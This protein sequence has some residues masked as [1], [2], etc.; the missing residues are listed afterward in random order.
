[1]KISSVRF[2]NIN[3]LRGE[4]FLAFDAAPLAESGLF[5]ITG[6]T[7]AGKT[8]ILDAITVALY[9]RAARY[10]DKS[11]SKPEN[12]M[13]RGTGE[14]YAEVEFESDGKRYRAKWSLTRAR[15]KADGAL[16]S[17]KMELSELQTELSK[18]STHPEHSVT[19]AV[20]GTLLTQKKS[21]VPAKVEEISGLSYEQFLRSVMLAQGKFAEFLKA[22]ES[23]RA[24]LLEH[25]TGTS[26]YTRIS[27]AAF[28]KAKLANEALQRLT[29]KLGDLR[30]LT[31][32]ERKAHEMCIA[33]KNNASA[34]LN[35]IIKT[36]RAALQWANDLATL[37]REHSVRQRNAEAAQR[38]FDNA[39][40]ERRTLERH[41]QS[42]Q[43]QARL[44]LLDK[45]TDEANKLRAALAE[46]ERTTIPTAS[47]ALQAAQNLAMQHEQTH[48]AAQKE[49][50]EAQA[51]FDDV[52]R[53]DSALAAEAE[54]LAKD[55]EKSS[56]VGTEAKALRS[57]VLTRTNARNEARASADKALLWLQQHHADKALEAALPMLRSDIENITT[58][59]QEHHTASKALAQHQAQQREA[60]ERVTTCTEDA[61]TSEK[62]LL[63]ATA[64]LQALH[65]H[66]EK[67][68]GGRT[69][70]ELE[71]RI[72]TCKDDGVALAQMIE[73]LETIIQRSKEYQGAEGT[74]RETLVRIG[75]LHKQQ[76]ELAALLAEQE[77]KRDLARRVLDQS[78]LIAKYEDDR[79]RLQ[80][81]APC[82]L[83]GAV[84]HP[85]AESDD[86]NDK[87]DE[88][89]HS[90]DEAA[91]KK[92]EKDVKSTSQQISRVQADVSSART[93]Q[94]N[95]EATIARLQTEMEKAQQQ[96]NDIVTA[97]SASLGSPLKA[98][99]SA[100]AREHLREAQEA[101]QAKR[102]EYAELSETKKTLDALHATIA[103][104]RTNTDSAKE[105]SGKSKTALELAAQT[106][107]QL[108]GNTDMLQDRV[109]T[110]L[111]ALERSK[112]TLA[113][114]CAAFDE[115]LPT[116][117][118][119]AQTL[120][121]QLEKR[122]ADFAEQLSTEQRLRGEAERLGAGLIELEKNCAA[123]EQETKRL[124]EDLAAKET[125]HQRLRAQRFAIFGDK[126]PSAERQRL[127]ASVDAAQKALAQAQRD[128]Q[129]AN[130]A[131]TALQARA[132]EDEQR[133]RDLERETASA[134]QGLLRAAQ[135]CGCATLDDLRASILP[136]ST[137]TQLESRIKS[138][139]DALLEQQTTLKQTAERLAAEQAKKLLG[140]SSADEAKQRLEAAE[141]EQRT[142]QQDI[143]AVRQVLDDD[144]AHKREH[145]ALADECARQRT[146]T[147]RWQKLSK[148]IGSF[149]G[150]SFRKFAQGLTL[151]RLVRLANAQLRRLNERYELLKVPDADLQLAIV[152][153]EQAGAVRPVESLSGGET[154]LMSL[155]LALGLSDL[156]SQKARIDSLF[157]DE[158]FGT[159][160]AQ[161]LEEVMNALENLRMN[162]K[163][164]GIISH[165]EILKERITTQVRVRKQGDGVSTLRVV[166]E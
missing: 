139:A 125:Q 80:T 82:P 34:T 85:F 12:L 81:G 161:T 93:E 45:T 38:E 150:D 72:N 118:K 42:A 3:S 66:V 62:N 89:K 37:E 65:T 100:E 107:K 115:K 60:A 129:A 111:A 137:A 46:A 166:Q 164:I 151:A 56:A 18:N 117:S 51:L 53:R 19:T 30:L 68:L 133:L 104:E 95:S 92:A 7:G 155:A 31:D 77:E 49:L 136:A 4:H 158:G 128:A 9:G 149:T 41:R 148:L 20:E 32:D 159:L 97:L 112:Q 15:K 143:G 75:A 165:V 146:E 90:D 145:A 84:H 127:E 74:H 109:N 21:E 40:P 144:T 79:L 33:E 58:A 138:L 132:K 119:A 25:M 114:R 27:M 99:L 36:F 43:L 52:L 22:S 48:F 70:S 78:R 83:C 73:L 147:A 106:V 160:D 142:L 94:T 64:A 156:A 76:Q 116:S 91:W 140:E 103:T 121:Q 135:E 67:V 101:R 57:D 54:N 1:M 11:K 10:D 44:A 29:G 55:R 59:Q 23:E 2:A 35:E 120:V 134:S 96:F 123:K 61:A 26:E 8:T 24:E 13:A 163:T 122:A 14:C 141:H 87:N 108:N 28:A 17:E 110:A 154:F 131:L 5:L 157:V 152:D 124:A 130:A 102:K 63:A 16:Q 153:T 105:A 6:A 69:Q 98:P 88:R 39:A 50:A 47:N 126:Q 71:E 162:G 86:E 113:E